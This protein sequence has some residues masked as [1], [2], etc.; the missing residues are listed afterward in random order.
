MPLLASAS[1]L[2]LVEVV[3]VLCLESCNNR[4]LHLEELGVEEEEEEERRE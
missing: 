3:E 2:L 4:G 1:R